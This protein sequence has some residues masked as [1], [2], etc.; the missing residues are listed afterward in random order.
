MGANWT[1]AEA[2]ATALLV[3]TSVA[4]IFYAGVQLRYERQYRAV[5][6]LEKQLAFFHSSKFR[7]ARRRLAA[8]RLNEDHDL[9]SLNL[10]EPPTAAFEVLD[11]YEHLGLLVKKRH[12]DLYDV[13]HTFYEW[14]QP[15]YADMRAVL[16][17]GENEWADHYSDFRRMMHGMDR[18]QQS[19]MKKRGSAH[20]RLWSDDRICE[21]YSYELEAAGDYVPVRRSRRLSRRQDQTPVADLQIEASSVPEPTEVE[22]NARMRHES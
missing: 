22:H 8:E 18:I 20:G 19:R 12:L 1:E 9:L 13:W 14:S 2:L 11:F 4:G 10:S 17:S 21:H 15:V 16:E 5:S 6:N 3:L 7:E